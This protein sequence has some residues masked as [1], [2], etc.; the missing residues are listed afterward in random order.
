MTKIRVYELARELNMDSKA[1]LARLKDLGMPLP[2][3]Q[4][5]LTA[6]Q[7]DKIR[8]VKNEDKPQVV[9]RRRRKAAEEGLE[10]AVEASDSASVS[11]VVKEP[12]V[13]EPVAAVAAESEVKEL[14]E[15][16]VKEPVIAATE[17]PAEVLSAAPVEPE[18]ETKKVEEP[19]AAAPSAAA[20]S[21]QRSVLETNL[22]K[23]VSKN[24][25]KTPSSFDALREASAP[26]GTVFKADNR[27]PRS[28]F[29]RPSDPNI[30]R[31]SFSGATIVRKAT[32]EER[33]SFKALQD[34]RNRP[35][36]RDDT[37]SVKVGPYSGAKPAPVKP[38]GV[39]PAGAVEIEEDV[40][41][42]TRWVKDKR[43]LRQKVGTEEDDR[44]IKHAPVSTNGKKRISTRDLLNS[45]QLGEEDV[46]GLEAAK[47]AGKRRTVYTPSELSRRSNKAGKKRKDLKKTQIT[48]PR[49]AYRVVRMERPHIAVAELARQLSV[50]GAEVVAKLMSQGMMV[51][52]NQDVDFDV[53]ALIASEYGYECKNVSVTE[54]DLLSSVRSEQGQV[55]ERPPIITVMGHVDHGKTSIL[56]AIRKTDV[57]AGESGGITQH[58]GAYM[59]EKDGRRV[60]F[61]DTPGHEAFSAMRARGAKV[62]DIVVLVV[63]ADDGVKPQTIEAISH[64]HSAKVPIIVAVN[65][66]DKPGIN[67]ERIYKELSEHGVQAEDWGGDVQFVKVSA[68]KGQGIDDLLDA[69][70]VQAEVLELKAPQEGLAE[71]VVVEAHLDKGRGPVATVI[72]TKGTLRIGDFMVAGTVTGRIRAMS[73]HNG[74]KLELALP[75]TPVQIIG[76]EAVPMSGEPV[77]V[78]SD[79]RLSKE[80]AQLRRD[81][82]ERS[83]KTAAAVSLE[84]LIGKVQQAEIPELPVILKADTQGSVEAIAASLGKLNSDL[85]RN[86]IVHRSVGGINESDINLAQ[87]SGAVILAFNVRASSAVTEMAERRGVVINY[88]SVIYELID[89]VKSLMA[90]KL[91]PVRTEVVLGHAEVRNAINV[92]KIGVIAG[93]AVLDGKITRSA[94]LRLIRNEVV[95]YSGKIA[96]LRRFKD[97]VKEVAHGYECGI[98]VENYSDIR[99]GDVIEAYTIEESAAVLNI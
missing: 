39:K 76:L 79:E 24:V 83:T 45:I 35:V 48:T 21:A 44:P 12:E 40:S 93:S 3:H 66:I 49:A 70:F 98:S 41:S 59:V 88:F 84:D 14:V 67:I 18:E 26:P 31:K 82:V 53:A 92:P 7:I 17:A 61:L 33:E 80:V 72:V 36:R 54:D 23:G 96:S 9:V 75:A 16:P 6:A 22:P 27:L 43:D 19:R 64:A 78:T 89:S 32:P 68:L 29:V 58:I 42:S 99:V 56:D 94:L 8:N 13:L 1:L 15:Q 38:V 52:L 28:G 34:N 73:D 46:D 4:S 97:D 50:K 60:T 77:H 90:G 87:A 25:S 71:G 63:A 51:T 95:I 65:K 37:G 69:I 10:P 74:K 86:L 55:Q 91:P 30:E 62:T 20:E 47:A 85:V 11:E 5:T 81:N 57:A 2:G